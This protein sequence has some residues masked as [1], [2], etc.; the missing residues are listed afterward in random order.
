MC[1][2]NSFLLLAPL[3][4]HYLTLPPSLSLF[5][6]H[7]ELSSTPP[8]PP[9]L[10]KLAAVLLHEGLVQLGDLYPHVSLTTHS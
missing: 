3:L 4:S 5:S 6:Q 2:R 7:S 9:S 1:R 8:T 10:Y